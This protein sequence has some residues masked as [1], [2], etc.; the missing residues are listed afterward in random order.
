MPAPNIDEI[1]KRL[2]SPRV[3]NLADEYFSA[4]ISPTYAIFIS[5]DKSTIR[6]YRGYKTY[7]PL[8]I[9]RSWANL[10]VNSNKWISLLKDAVQSRE[11]YTGF[12]SAI[13]GRLQKY[14]NEKDPCS[15][16]N[17]GRSRKLV[18]LFMKFSIISCQIPLEIRSKLYGF[19]NVPL[20]Q[21]SIKHL[22]GVSE[23]L[24][25]ILLPENTWTMGFI[26]ENNYE[27][28]QSIIR[29]VARKAC[30][31][32]IVFDIYAWNLSHQEAT[33]HLFDKTKMN[34]DFSEKMHLRKR[35]SRA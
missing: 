26:E 30:V 32:P 19:I 22:S 11:K 13:N 34:S 3:V 8:S 31:Q 21:Y 25:K 20:D 35:S 27:T 14:W 12:H 33:D 18:D 9:F 1:V 15:Q 10:E 23:K 29:K 7:R 4:K 2:Q 6:A 17:Y 28:L 5:V 16:P 24:G